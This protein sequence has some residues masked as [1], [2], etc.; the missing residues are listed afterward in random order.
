MKRS[1]RSPALAIW[2]I[3]FLII[4]TSI[5]YADFKVKASL[6]QIA[7]AK[8]QVGGTKAVNQV[9][10]DKIVSNIEYKDIV[11]VHKDERGR[12]VLIQPNTVML[13]KI[14]STTVIEISESLEK[15]QADSIEIPMGQITG[16]SLLAG[17]GPRLKVKIV[18]S[19]E[20]YVEVL[21]KFEAAGINQ[22]RHLIYFKIRNKLKIAV[23]F[24][25]ETIEVSTTVPLA[26]TIVVG[27]VPDTFVDVK[28]YTEALY[29]F[30]GK[31]D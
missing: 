18:P 17:Y 28:G 25:N 4:F 6:I 26:E 9:V 27:E 20:V 2:I 14:M 16:S 31:G 29:P 12:I 30:R 19:G 15:L 7:K 1:K 11:C 13:N 3:L 10:N 5:I 21:N 23:P 22:T 8:V 24:L